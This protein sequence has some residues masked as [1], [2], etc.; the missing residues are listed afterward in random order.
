MTN[1][2]LRRATDFEDN[3][4]ERKREG[5][6]RGEFR[7]TIVAFSN[8]LPEDRTGV[9]FIGLDDA[10][11]PIGLGN[12]DSLQ[13][14][15]TKICSEDIYPSVQV[16]MQVLRIDEVPV[17]AVVVSHSDQQPHFSGP[18]YIRQ[19]SESVKASPQL[20]ED[21]INSRVEV[22]R[23]ILREK[24]KTWTVRGIGLQVGQHARVRPDYTQVLECTIEECD[25]HC[26]RLSDI[27]SGRRMT[28]S[29]KSVTI[30]YDEMKHRPLLVVEKV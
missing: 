30:L 2:L 3:F 5:A 12:P 17:L 18:A 24:D 16:E 10:G 21:L 6:G 4:T 14:T 29:L 23:R 28:V 9:L 22:C 13:K 20:Y 25:A 27:S 19:G 11:K 1:E 15:I 7:K 26:V 8:S